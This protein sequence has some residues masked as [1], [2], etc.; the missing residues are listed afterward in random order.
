MANRREICEA[1]T[2]FI[3]LG[4]KDTVDG[5]CS[6]EIKKTTSSWQESYDK[7]RQCEKAKTSLSQQR[8]TIVKAM[9]FPL[10]MYRYEKWTIK[11]AEHCRIDAF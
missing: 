10:V 5:D 6:H 7:P 8:S 1:V 3:L 11:K 2:D 4:S 9:I